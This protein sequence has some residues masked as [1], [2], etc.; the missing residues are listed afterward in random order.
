[1]DVQELVDVGALAAAAIKVA[2]DARTKI[3]AAKAATS[4]GGAK[5][6]LAEAEAIVKAE[7]ATLEAPVL[8][9]V[10]DLIA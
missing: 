1:M 5:V 4:D 7:L 6:T 9:L 10:K 2:G 8:A 3:A